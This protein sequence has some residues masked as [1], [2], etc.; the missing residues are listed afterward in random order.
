MGDPG[1]KLPRPTVFFRFIISWID[2]L[3]ANSST[4]MISRNHFSV[5]VSIGRT[6]CFTLF[7][8]DCVQ[9]LRQTTKF[10]AKSSNVPFARIFWTNAKE[11]SQLGPIANIC[12]YGLRTY[13]EERGREHIQI[14]HTFP[15]H[16]GK[17]SSTRLA[18]PSQ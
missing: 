4:V 6:C 2:H 15:Y 7:R 17:S 10:S 12:I 13:L 5:S 11:H 16:L 14:S 1:P 3:L 18:H 8:F 9:S